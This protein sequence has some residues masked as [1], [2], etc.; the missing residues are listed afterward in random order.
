MGEAILLPVS[1]MLAQYLYRQ[2]LTCFRFLRSQEGI[3]IVFLVPPGKDIGNIEP[4]RKLT[5]HGDQRTALACWRQRTL[6]QVDMG[7][8]LL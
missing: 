2:R 7:S 1:S 6:H 4:L 8:R 5:Q 3:D